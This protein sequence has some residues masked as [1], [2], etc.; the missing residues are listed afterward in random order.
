MYDQG[1]PNENMF[2]DY[3]SNNEKSYISMNLCDHHEIGSQI[4]KEFLA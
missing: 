1:V 4:A 2:Y 3:I